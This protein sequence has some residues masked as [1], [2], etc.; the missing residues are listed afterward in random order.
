MYL[1]ISSSLSLSNHP[2]ISQNEN[3]ILVNSSLPL[4][5]AFWDPLISPFWSPQ[6]KY[7]FP[8]KHLTSLVTEY[9]LVL[10]GVSLPQG[11]GGCQSTTIVFWPGV[12]LPWGSKY[13]LTPAPSHYLKQNWLLIKG[14]LR[15]SPESNFTRN[16]HEC[17]LYSEVTLFKSLPHLTGNNVFT[18]FGHHWFQLKFI[19]TMRQLDANH[20][21]GNNYGKMMFKIHIQRN[22]F[23]NVGDISFLVAIL[24]TIDYLLMC[25]LPVVVINPAEGS[26]LQYV[27]NLNAVKCFRHILH[28]LCMESQKRI[29]HVIMDIHNSIMDVH[30]S[31]MDIHNC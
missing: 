26:V 18:A 17:N 14:V 15:H 4:I 7:G 31:I 11:G 2:W 16:A 8:S 19:Y 10:W 3:C 24:F 20:P 29:N 28:L 13:Y 21:A 6:H 25:T 5:R 9:L 23:E 1:H 30:N 22:T 27:C 12:T